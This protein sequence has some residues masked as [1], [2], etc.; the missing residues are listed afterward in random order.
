MLPYF[1]AIALA[2]ASLS[3]Y[4]SAF[5][6]P[7]I[8][9]KDDFLWSGVGLFYALILWICAGHITGSVLL[10]QGAAVTL[11]LMFGWQTVRLRRAIAHPNEKTNL[12][13]FSAVSWLQNRVS[14]SKKPV[15]SSSAKSAPSSEPAVES[16]IPPIVKAPTVEA[17]KAEILAPE[18]VETAQNKEIEQSITENEIKESEDLEFEAFIADEDAETIIEAY[19]PKDI[20]SISWEN[21]A[22]SAE[23]EAIE[24]DNTLKLEESEQDLENQTENKEVNNVE[25]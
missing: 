5:F 16:P 11:V 15:T 4:L 17:K 3:L 12:D 23:I 1:L 10:G 13:Q 21:K 22:P 20:K 8:H 9:R 6:I 19:Q 7:E 14:G 18:S 25:E 2:V 24:Q